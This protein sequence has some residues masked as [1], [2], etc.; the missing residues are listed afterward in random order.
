M[1]YLI[2]AIVLVLSTGILAAA[3]VNLNI[4][5]NVDGKEFKMNTEYTNAKGIKYKITRFE[6]YMCGFELDGQDLDY[7]L[8]S[9]GSY[10][11]YS[12]GSY[13]IDKV[14]KITMSF[15]VKKEDNIDQDPN[16]RGPLHPLGP[17][18]PSMHW[19][20]AAGYRFWVVEGIV[21]H[22]NDGVYDKSFQ[23]HVLG[24]EAFRTMT[25]DVDAVSQGGVI[26]ININFDVQKLLKTVD[27]TKFVA[28][29]DFYNNVPEIRDFIN[30]IASSEV[31]TSKTTSSVETNDFIIEIFPNPA[32]NYLKVGQQYL[33]SDYSIIAIDGAITQIGTIKSNQINLDNLVS[34][35]Y[36][37][38]IYDSNGNINTAKFVK[39]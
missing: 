33:N 37:I 24:D 10:E 34:G 1:K 13:D 29:H 27:M 15:G 26:D 3:E 2:I 12:L 4:D 18:D 31:V 6:Y 38:R 32:T 35:T 25:L 14:N 30:N 16:K 20:W 21:D 36:I 17:K 19:G 5:Y 8:L 11:K 9:N 7:Y 22:D 23:Y 28:Y 39:N